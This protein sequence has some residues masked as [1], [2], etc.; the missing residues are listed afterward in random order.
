[1][2]VGLDRLITSF[3]RK[4]ESSF[5][6]RNCFPPLRELAPAALNR[7]FSWRGFLARAIYLAVVLV[8]CGVVGV[9]AQVSAKAK[10]LHD[11]AFVFDGHI[12]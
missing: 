6:G 12:T 5:S 11:A 1:M 2:W 3:P 4:R 8:I 9:Q 10:Q 7:L